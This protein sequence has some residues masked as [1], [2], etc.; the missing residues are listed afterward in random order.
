MVMGIAR[1]DDYQLVSLFCFTFPPATPGAPVLNGH[2]R[3]Q[4]IVASSG[5]KF[6]VLN[7]TDLDQGLPCEELVRRAKVIEPLNE[8]TREIIAYDLTLNVEPTMN[9][10]HIAAVIARCGQKVD[11]EYIVEFTNPGGSFEQ[12][13]AC[14]D[15]GLLE[16]YLWISV[17][18]LLGTPAFYSAHRILQ[19]RQAHNE[20]SAIFFTSSAFYAA[21]VWLFTGHL[22]VYSRNG[23]GL[24]M[25][26]FVAEFLDFVSATMGTLVLLALVHGVYVTRPLVPNGTDERR[27]LLNVVG[28][29]TA[30]NL[31]STLACG[32]KVDGDL[33][34]FGVLRG[35]SWSLPYIMARAYVGFFCLN[36]GL[37]LAQEADAVQKKPS[38]LRFTF[39]ALVWLES[40][41]LVMMFS[42]ADSWH[43]D[44]RMLDMANL[45]FYGTVLY[46]LW[47]S[48]FGTLFS[49]IKPTERMHPYAE[50]GLSG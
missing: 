33:S 39:V 11:S 12:H 21:R 2:V 27:S 38:I 43:R 47:P 7:Q 30:T 8:R 4:T 48:R 20:V 16:S 18:V 46:D 40:L 37:K 15:Q 17:I 36:R 26:L 35:S 24:G 49:C 9:R 5:H 19:R 45:C 32:F 22:L 50:F 34:P 13:F 28:L 31:I 42:S 25:L 29:I 44:A 41:P 6:L 1:G 3:S 10:Q 14:S 23:S